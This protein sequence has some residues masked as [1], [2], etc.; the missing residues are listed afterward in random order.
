MVGFKWRIVEVQHGGSTIE[1]PAKLNGFVSFTHDR[2]LLA[3]DGVNAHFGE[4]HLDG[5]GYRVSTMGVTL[6]GYSG[7]DRAQLALVGAVQ[8]VTEQTT[9]VSAALQG[10]R[11]NLSRS[12][13]RLTCTKAGAAR[14]P[15]RPT[16]TRSRS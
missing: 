5:G 16:P 14:N 6:V 11:L 15:V 2:H 9:V 10:D 12:G 4:F 13:Y 3:N 8:A 7:N 1:I